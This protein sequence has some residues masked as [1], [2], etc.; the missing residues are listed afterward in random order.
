MANTRSAE[1]RKRQGERRR[2]RN[3][4]VRTRVKGAVKKVREALAQGDV[5][6][7]RAALGA[8]SRVLDGAASKGVLH[9]NAAS[10]R[11]AR[12][13]QAVAVLKPAS[14]APPSA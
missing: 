10:R 14:A 1:K 11:I 7:A 12:L 6:G 5:A 4:Q 3:V 13:A 8:A 9:P 2:L